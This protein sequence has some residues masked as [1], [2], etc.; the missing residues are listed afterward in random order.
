MAILA[1]CFACIALLY[2]MVGFGGG[3]SYTAL[4]IIA[5]GTAGVAISAVPLISLACNIIVVAGG[6]VRFVWA[7]AVPWARALPLI[8]IAAPLAYLGG[9]T[10]VADGVLIVIF[11]MALLVSALLLFFDLGVPRDLAVAMDSYD[12]WAVTN[13][14]ESAQSIGVTHCGDIGAQEKPSRRQFSSWILLPLAGALGYLAG[15]VGIGGGI[16]LA[17]ILHLLHWARAHQVAATA[18]LFILINSMFGLA[19][20]ILKRPET[21]VMSLW[22]G[23][24]PLPLAVLFGGLLGSHLSVTLASARVIRRL[25]AMLVGLVAGRLLLI[26]LGVV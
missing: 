1:V 25:T 5:S 8:L 2:A 13:R 21:D 18:S 14:K 7:R 12:S 15:V 10:M 6:S 4:L 26:G 19:G 20:Q 9:R 22:N 3:S 17:P 11:G 23:Y 24:W 16:F